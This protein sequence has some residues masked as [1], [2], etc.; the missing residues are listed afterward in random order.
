MLYKDKSGLEER[1]YNKEKAEYNVRIKRIREKEESEAKEAEKI[2]GFDPRR[3][4]NRYRSFDII[5]NPNAFSHYS[6]IGY[7]CVCARDGGSNEPDCTV[8]KYPNYIGTEQDDFDH[9]YR[10]YYFKPLEKG[11]EN[12]KTHI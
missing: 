10:Y 7:L 6:K 2:F 4:G 11:D 12:E 1:E 3:I 9:T 5:K 8:G